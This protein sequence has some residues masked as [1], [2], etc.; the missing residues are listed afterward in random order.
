MAVISGYAKLL[1][2]KTEES[3]KSTAEAIISEINIMNEVISELLAFAKPT[4]LNRKKIDLNHLLKEVV[5]TTGRNNEAVEVSLDLEEKL[6]IEADEVLLRQALSNI[7][8][9]A[10]EAMPE[11]GTFQ[12]KL[13]RLNKKAEIYVSDTGQGIPDVIV[14]K[15]FLPFY[16]TKEKGIG[17][18]LALVQKIIVHHG[19]T[20]SVNSLEGSG[21]TFVITLPVK[22]QRDP[23]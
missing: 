1:L 3:N 5:E 11:G 14:K 23:C 4:V 6:T 12:L 18:G 19:G 7:C 15:I 10:F 22:E 13:K 9:N 17:M 8:I 2:K 21:S 16:T 20:I